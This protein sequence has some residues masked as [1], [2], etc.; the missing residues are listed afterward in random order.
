[1]YST[2]GTTTSVYWPFFYV[3]PG[4]PVPAWVPPSLAMEENLWNL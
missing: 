1:M 2:I 4:E 3:N